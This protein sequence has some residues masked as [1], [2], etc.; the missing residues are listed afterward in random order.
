MK[1]LL[2]PHPRQ[3]PDPAGRH[4]IYLPLSQ[5]ANYNLIAQVKRAPPC[6]T[7]RPPLLAAPASNSPHRLR[8]IYEGETLLVTARHTFIHTGHTPETREREKI[9][10]SG[11]CAKLFLPKLSLL[12]LLSAHF[13]IDLIVVVH[14]HARRRQHNFGTR[15]AVRGVARGALPPKASSASQHRRL[16]KPPRHR[17][18]PTA[19]FSFVHDGVRAS[20]AEKYRPAPRDCGL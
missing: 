16:R 2:T 12:L 15:H 8:A 6:C 17:G 18:E 5:T 10:Q 7:S 20:D 13:V 11:Y 3:A 9:T 1:C 19:K 4:R 14:R